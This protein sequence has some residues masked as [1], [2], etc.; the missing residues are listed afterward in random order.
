MFSL[1]RINL[2]AKRGVFAEIDVRNVK[3]F[4][5]FSAVCNSLRVGR[6]NGYCKPRNLMGA[7]FGLAS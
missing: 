7:L 3:A 4:G 5:C 1:Y 6:V 2:T